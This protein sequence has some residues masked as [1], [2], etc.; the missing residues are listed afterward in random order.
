MA[1]P[2]LHNPL[3]SSKFPA[4][5]QR[6]VDEPGNPPELAVW[7]EL[8][9]HGN[10]HVQFEKYQYSVPFRLVGRSLW[11]PGA[12]PATGQHVLV[13]SLV[14]AD[15][16]CQCQEKCHTLG[17]LNC[18]TSGNFK[19]WAS[20]PLENFF[21]FRLPSVA[22]ESCISISTRACGSSNP[23]CR[24]HGSG[25]TADPAWPALRSESSC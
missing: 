14:D 25:A 1:G 19:G 4:L 24:R 9:V 11:L 12:R 10:A 23:G 20:P 6:L 22:P 7:A 18:H 17:N 3:D 21:R 8:K 5:C 2:R 15:R 16:Q 13:A